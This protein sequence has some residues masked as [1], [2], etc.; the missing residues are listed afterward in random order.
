MDLWKI[1]ADEVTQCAYEKGVMAK[2][3]CVIPGICMHQLMPWIHE[4]TARAHLLECFR[5]KA[6]GMTTKMGLGM[7]NKIFESWYGK[8]L[9]AEASQVWNNSFVLM[10]TLACV[11]GATICGP[12]KWI[13][14]GGKEHV[15]Y[16]GGAH[17]QHSPAQT[18]QQQMSPMAFGQRQHQ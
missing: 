6:E 16:G 3:D 17:A 1:H 14:A 7:Q 9:A 4:S 13:G 18:A 12:L 8:E 11:V 5:L 10:F 2:E 15:D